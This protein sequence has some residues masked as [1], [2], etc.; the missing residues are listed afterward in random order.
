[1]NLNVLLGLVICRIHTI[2]YSKRFKPSWFG[3]YGISLNLFGFISPNWVY[4]YKWGYHKADI[5][6]VVATVGMSW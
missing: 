6:L 3:I 2:I 1:M 5:I 4:F